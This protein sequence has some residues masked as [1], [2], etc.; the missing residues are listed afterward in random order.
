MRRRAVPAPGLPC[1]LSHVDN[2]QLLKN[3]AGWRGATGSRRR[4][5]PPEGRRSRRHAATRRATTSRARRQCCDRASRRSPSC[6]TSS[7]RRTAGRCCSSSRRWT[8]PARTARSS[9]SCPASIRRAARCTRSRR[10][11]RGARSRLPV[12]LHEAPARARP[13]RHLQPLATTRKCSSSACIPETPRQRRS[14]RRS[15]VTQAT[16]GSSASRTSATSSA[17]STATA[18]SIRK[19]FLHVSQGGA[20]TPVPRAAR[21]ADEE[22]E[23]LGGDVAE[24]A[25]WKRLHGGL[26]G[27]D[28]PHRHRRRAVVRRARRQQVVHAPG[29]RGRR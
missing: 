20:A 24:R 1:R 25:H 7:T 18:S 19:F 12:A 17:T 2:T 14:C 13:H 8:P 22:L 27:H 28:P 16:S 6:R 10:R 23:V 4:R 15:C 11:P 3:A 29:G 26:R 9:T 5:V 21:R